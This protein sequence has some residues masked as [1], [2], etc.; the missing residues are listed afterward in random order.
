MTNELKKS[1]EQL[2]TTFSSYPFPSAIVGCP[3]CVSDTDKAKIHNSQLRELSGDD[4]SRYAFKAMTTWGDVKDFKYYLPRILELLS[5]T[6]FIVDTF[7][8]LGKLNYGKWTT[9][10][11][12]EQAVIK[13]FLLAW[14]EDLIK[15]KNYFDQEA[16]IE[17]YKLLGTVDELL[18][19][20]EISFDDNSFQNVVDMIDRC[21]LDLIN[22]SKD[23]KDFDEKEVEKIRLWL[24]SKKELIET[25]FFHYENSDKELAQKISDALYIIEYYK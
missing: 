19:K 15:N 17:I 3:C 25:G 8:V 1:I 13:Q 14:W 18:D 4:L 6:D 10:A 20:W 9:W 12:E 7:V 2:Y 11:M 22:D 16:F 23:Y 5:T 24:T 21:Y